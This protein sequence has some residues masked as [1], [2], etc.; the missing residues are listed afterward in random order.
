MS[1]IEQM[2]T[3]GKECIPFIFIIDFELKAPQIIPLHL[4]DKDILFKVNQH[5]NYDLQGHKSTSLSF[6]PKPIAYKV[7][8]KSFRGAQ[9]EIFYGNSFLLNLT[10]PTPVE[11]NYSLKELF[12]V[13]M[14]KYKLYYKDQF[15]VS[16]PEIFVQIKNGKIFD[17]R[18]IA[19]ETKKEILE[20][21]EK[22]LIED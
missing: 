11:T 21:I 9:K 15:I 16:S 13:S 14:A 2:N 20:L 1:W 5:K 6:V 10:F 4:L 22:E 12:E 17:F 3:Y 7:F 18:I 19:K 8:E